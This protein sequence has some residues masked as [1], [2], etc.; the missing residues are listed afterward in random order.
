MP[1]NLPADKSDVEST[2][3][4]I[5]DQRSLG[6]SHYVLAER[7]M[8][9]EAA[10]IHKERAEDGTSDTLTYILEGGFRGFHKFTRDHLIEEWNDGACDK[11]YELYEDNELPW[12]IYEDD[13]LVAIE[14]DATGEVAKG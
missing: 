6:L 1:N 14:E 7:L 10:Q 9:V 4:I 13:P 12:E 8:Q 2:D 11:F 3:I 5:T